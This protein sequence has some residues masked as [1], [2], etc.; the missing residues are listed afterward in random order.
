M[1]EK[2]RTMKITILTESELRQCVALDQETLEAVAEGFSYL[3][4]GKAT[5]PPIMRIPVPEN[6]GEVDVKS[7]YIRGP[8]SFAVKIASG[9]SKNTDLGLQK[10]SGMMILISSQTGF[11][12]AVLLDNGYL[13]Q[14]RTGA[15]GALA[16]DFLAR[17]NVETV[18]VIGSGTQA[19]YQL[20]ALKLV[21]EFVRLLVY[22]I[23]SEEVECYAEEMSAL[24]DVEV[25]IAGKAEMVVR[26][27]DAVVTTTPSREPYLKAEWL[28]PGL[29][30]T[31]MGADGEDKQE[32]FPDVFRN[33]D[34][35]A[36]DLK[37]QCFRLGELH[38]GLDAGIL[39]E[40]QPIVELGDMTCGR[41][42]GRRLDEEI[43]FCDLTGVGVQD[44]K[45]ALL[46][47]QNAMQR[48]LGTQIDS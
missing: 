1:L 11:P 38:H 36:C 47:Y 23:V 24:L 37:A 13:T 41:K 42:S 19:R 22:G 4:K 2:G 45:I 28:H 44:T 3:S 7:A 14:V 5:V 46:A 33:V 26:E 6:R 9:F 17:Q 27:S 12:E 29:H 48:G 40:D 20:R 35:L 25:V 31:A 15:A 10:N 18:G 8:E 32:L 34:I 16:A 43:T 39:S 21:R 30:I